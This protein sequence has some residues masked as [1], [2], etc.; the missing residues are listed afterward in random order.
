[1]SPDASAVLKTYPN[2]MVQATWSAPITNRFLIDAGYTFHPES[3]SL[4]PQPDV[5][6]D[7]YPMLE[8]STNMAYRARGSYTRHR[9][10]TENSKFNVSY[11]TGSHAF[12]VGF[13]EMH[14]WRTIFNE[15]LG[16]A[17]TLRLFNGV[18]NSIQEYTFPYTTKVN[19][20]DYIGLFAQDQWTFNRDD[21]QHGHPLRRDERL[22]AGAVLPGDAARRRADRSMPVKNVPNW[23]DINPRLGVAY[24][25]FGN[26]KTAVKANF[27]RF[28]QGVTTGFADLVNPIVTS[29]NN[30][31]RTW[32]D[33]NGNLLP[34][35]RPLDVFANGECGA[36]VE[37]QLRPER[38]HDP[39][40]PEFLS[41]WGKR[42]YDWEV[43]AGDPARAAQRPV[44]H[45]HLHAPLVGQ[46]PGHRQPAR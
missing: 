5:P 12:K 33:T 37:H 20:K 34:R 8:L 38:R 41:G 1:M 26:G 7:T 39:Y 3:W 4:W 25:L 10:N 46:L 21:A 19:L 42:P 11:V 28:V 36:D 45:G 31:T 40:D 14:G 23:K 16:T 30:A 27:G 2:L 18:P 24:D 13:Q 17:T 44:G 15:A 6:W 22:R 29:V 9:S 35:L 43:Q 32:R